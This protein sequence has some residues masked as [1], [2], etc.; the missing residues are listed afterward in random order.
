MFELVRL[1]IKYINKYLLGVM[2]DSIA[3][4]GLQS[5]FKTDSA[6]SQSNWVPVE[7]SGLIG[8]S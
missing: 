4:V 8:L 5:L 7:S 3:T 2:Y 6:D 1:N